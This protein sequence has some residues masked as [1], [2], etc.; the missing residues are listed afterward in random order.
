[1]KGAWPVSMP[2][3]V[4]F[5]KYA[6]PCAFITLQRGRISQSEFEMLERAAIAGA[7]VARADLERIFA[8]AM[9]RLRKLAEKKGYEM[10]SRELVAE[11]YFTNHNRIIDEGEGDYGNAPEVLREL[12]KIFPA[13]VVRFEQNSLGQSASHTSVLQGG[14][15][16]ESH[17]SMLLRTFEVDTNS[18]GGVRAFEADTNNVGV[19]VKMPGGKL[20]AVNTL[21]VGKLNEGDR[22]MVHYGYACEKLV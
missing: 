19:V 2:V 11:Y 21:L 16:E 10:W 7:V 17:T 13:V 15:Q 3:E 6:F 1:M 18:V 12:C 4:Y 9:R 22:V 14:V 20:R 8:P 5:L